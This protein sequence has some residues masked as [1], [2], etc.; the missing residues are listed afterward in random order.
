MFSRIYPFVAKF[1]NRS[2]KKIPILTNWNDYSLILGKYRACDQLLNGYIW[3]T[4]PLTVSNLSLPSNRHC[5]NSCLWNTSLSVM[6]YHRAWALGTD[7]LETWP[8]HLGHLVVCDLKQVTYPFW[9]S[10]LSPVLECLEKPPLSFLNQK[11]RSH[12]WLLPFLAVTIFLFKALPVG[13][14][15]KT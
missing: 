7:T 8:T 3:T 9:A 14:T 15:L 11:L 10:I 2:F 1:E 4:G 12:P 6:Y 5:F 13:F